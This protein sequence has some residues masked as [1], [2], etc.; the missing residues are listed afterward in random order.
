VPHAC[1]DASLV[2]GVL[3]S[4]S[5]SSCALVPPRRLTLALQICALA[6]GSNARTSRARVEYAGHAVEHDGRREHIPRTRAGH[7]P[8]CERGCPLAGGRSP[9][10]AMGGCGSIFSSGAVTAQPN[11]EHVNLTHFTL[12]KVVG[13]GGF[14]KV[15]ACLR[16]L[17]H[18]LMAVKRM[19]KC[20]LVKKESHIRMVWT[21][22]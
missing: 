20:E 22:R 8:R 1:A 11:P 14:G 13:K 19:H 18:K 17:D 16:L 9:A 12:L 15:N 10:V 21:E 5:R 2:D 7:A 4:W 3:A 6:A